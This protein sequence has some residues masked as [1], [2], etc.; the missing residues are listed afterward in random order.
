MRGKAYLKWLGVAAA[1]ALM[2]GA[3]TTDYAQI[4]K[5]KG[6]EATLV[7][8]EGKETVRL[9]IWATLPEGTQLEVTVGPNK[10][11]FTWTADEVNQGFLD[12]GHLELS[13]GTEVTVK[14]LYD[15]TP[16][17][18]H[19]P[20]SQ[21]PKGSYK[22]FCTILPAYFSV[23]GLELPSSARIN[24]PVTIAATIQNTGEE[25]GTKDVWLEIEGREVERRRDLRLAPNE[26]TVV[27]F[28]RSFSS[29]GR[30]SVSVFTPDH[31][32]SATLSVE[33][34]PAYFYVGSVS[35]SPSPPFNVG[36]TA[37]FSA[38][39]ENRGD[40]AGTKPVWLEIDGSRV[41]ETTLTLRPGQSETV[42]FNYTFSSSG[43]YTARIRSP[44]DSSFT[45]VIVQARPAYFQVSS[46][47]IPSSANVNQ[48]VSFSARITNTGESSGSQYIRLIIDGNRVDSR[49]VSLGPRSSETVYFSRTFFYPGSYSV[50]IESDNDYCSG[51]IR[52]SPANQPPRI[53]GIRTIMIYR[54][55][56]P[57][58]RVCIYQVEVSFEDPDGDVTTIIINREPYN[59]NVYG[60][61][62]GVITKVFEVR[63]VLWIYSVQLQDA[64]GL[65]S[66]IVSVPLLCV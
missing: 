19:I 63:G 64:T 13:G 18:C 36:T 58:E 52:I 65:V 14:A 55:I 62:S 10:I 59:A 17:E 34:R 35:V 31:S 12:T 8:I 1:L 7:T 4:A 28:T 3:G 45:D 32:R 39:I 2:L 47:S 42:R 38:A 15:K 43:R 26:S 29:S 6:V 57:H 53:T 44:D 41:R 11:T 56:G 37:T 22:T 46:C 49:Y 16:N 21:V 48:S 30:Y 50:R 54:Y 5:D 20:L 24:T 23:T 60:Q 25:P 27:R 66:N 9:K 51:S 33:A 61:T 40:E